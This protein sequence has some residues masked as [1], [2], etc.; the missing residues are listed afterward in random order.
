MF[1]SLKCD[2]HEQLE[3][4]M[5][6]I[7]RYGLGVVLHLRQE[8]RG[9]GLANKIR[10]YELQSFGHDTIDTNRLLGLPDDPRG[11]EPAAAMIEHLGIESIR[12]LTNNPHKLPGCRLATRS[13]TPPS[14]RSS[15]PCRTGSAVSPC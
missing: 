5:A 6:E 13:S 12:L 10:A 4:A 14:R 7:G 9:I 11:Y 15:A 8:G 1:G 3:A 2:C